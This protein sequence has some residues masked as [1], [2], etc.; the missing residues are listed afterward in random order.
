MAVL[1]LMLSHSVSARSALVM[2]T[3]GCLTW[4]M[5]FSEVANAWRGITAVL[6]IA[7][8]R[9]STAV[10]TL[11]QELIVKLKHIGVGIG[12]IVAWIFLIAGFLKNPATQH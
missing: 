7:T 4:L 5:A 10:D 1:F 3:A 8:K 2:V 12:L 6:A 11:W 9:A